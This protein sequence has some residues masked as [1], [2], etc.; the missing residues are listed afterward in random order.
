M[1]ELEAAAENVLGRTGDGEDVEVYGLHRA[2]TTVHA[3][4]GGEIIHV[5]R[6]ETR[7]IGVRAVA[8]G[9]MGYAS[10]A[11]L[12][13]P[14]LT[15]CVGQARD[16]ALLA[17]VD[18]AARL[19]APQVVPGVPNLCH[20]DLVGTPLEH[21]VRLAADLARRVATLD[22]RVR[23]VDTATYRDEVATVLIAS[24]RGM[25]VMHERGFVELSVDVVAD[26]GET[27]AAD[28]GHYTGRS[29]LECDV[30]AIAE[31]A[32]RR[33]VRLLGPRRPAPPGV[34]VL[35]DPDA[36]A[37][38]LA[39]A[40]RG[41]TASAIGSGR[42]PFAD[43]SG[44]PVAA[45]CVT[46]VDDGLHP[47][48]PLT[49]PFD[50]EG[51]PRQRTTLIERGTATGVLHS[52]ATAAAA[53]AERPSTGNA[54]RGSHKSPPVV[55]PTTLVL[56]PTYAAEDLLTHS[57]DLIYL[58]Q[59]TGS[60]SGVSAANGRIEVGVIGFRV[61]DGEVAGAVALP[62]STTVENLLQQVLAV[63][64]DGRVVPESPVLAPTVVCHSRA[65]A[66]P[67]AG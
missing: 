56:T 20:P 50:D 45:P 11:D 10:T 23:G 39:A 37:V 59:L 32:V 27:V 28:T 2:V 60:Q 35:F 51:T 9:R 5:G 57:P 7:G 13:G 64:D 25:N 8:G 4:T 58:Q 6:G 16:N 3:G 49:A 66:R 29:P 34:P 31:A 42:G 22:P 65:V 53:D 18:P 47:L 48:S 40:G 12:T 33:T 46:L 15:H 19:P 14:G 41:F 61:R 17:E 38:F 55:A 1:I 30:E 21:K 26:D 36:S 52:I 44:G 62:L 63:G 24:T 67:R 54:R 43:R